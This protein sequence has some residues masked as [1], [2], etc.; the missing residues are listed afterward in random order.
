MDYKR[1]IYVDAPVPRNVKDDF[2]YGH[3][4]RFTEMDDIR[5]VGIGSRVESKEI[6][7][8]LIFYTDLRK[9]V[10]HVCCSDFGFYIKNRRKINRFQAVIFTID[11]GYVNSDVNSY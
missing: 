5:G 3:L 2:T 9:A 8:F 1:G 10:L 7:R 4:Y 11:D 6:S